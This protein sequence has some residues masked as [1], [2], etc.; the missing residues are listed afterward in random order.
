MKTEET[1][2]IARQEYTATEEP[3]LIELK[4]ACY[5]AI[6]GMGA[7][8][9]E[10]FTRRLAA[11]TEVYEAL[12]KNL[13]SAGNRIER[14]YLEGLWWGVAGPGDFFSAPTCDWA[15]RLMYRVPDL[16]TFEDLNQLIEE[17]KESGSYPEV[18]KIRIESLNEGPCIQILHVGPYMTEKVSLDKMG[19]YAREK[20]LSFHGLHHEIYLNRSQEVPEEELRT[21]LRMPVC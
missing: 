14:A 13:E 15:W 1:S 3:Q 20:G 10:Q 4:S 6:E 12:R 17:F 2:L 7:P 11:L 18:A 21:I 16:L 19:E 5:L 8:D 9:G